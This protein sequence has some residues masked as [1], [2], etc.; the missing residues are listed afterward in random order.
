MKKIFSF[1]M[2]ACLVAA[3]CTGCQPTNAPDGEK[4]YMFRADYQLTNKSDSTTWEAQSTTIEKAFKAEGVTTDSV[5]FVL[6]GKDSASVSI[7]LAEKMTRIK[8]ELQNAA[9]DVNALLMVYGT[10]KQYYYADDDKEHARRMWYISAVGTP[11]N[12]ETSECKGTS[13]QDGVN[14]RFCD[15]LMALNVHLAYVTMQWKSEFYVI[16][17]DLNSYTDDQPIYLFLHYSSKSEWGTSDAKY[18]DVIAVYDKEGKEPTDNKLRI[19]GRTYYRLTECCDLNKTAGGDW[20]WLYATTDYYDGYYLFGKYCKAAYSEYDWSWE[21]FKNFDPWKH[22]TRSYT[23]GSHQCVERVVQRYNRFGLHEGNAEV[24]CCAG[25]NHI[26]LILS[27]AT[28]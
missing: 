25:G 14:Y 24:N 1:A 6:K 28:K 20:I 17:Y 11:E 8:G 13:T 16:N 18:T 9:V 15:R 22:V 27:Y 7:V 5:G 23:V 10:E 4:E 12:E 21:S 2:L 19:N 26:Y 3:A